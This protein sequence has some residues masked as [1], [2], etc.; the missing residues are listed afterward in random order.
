MLWPNSSAKILL[1][2]VRIWS[3]AQGVQISYLWNF[4][5]LEFVTV[6]LDDCM[7]LPITERAILIVGPTVIVIIVVMVVRVA[8]GRRATNI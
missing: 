5:K 4:F 7:A 1:F 3:R 8:T 6:C 2:L